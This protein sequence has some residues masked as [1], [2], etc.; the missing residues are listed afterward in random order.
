MKKWLLILVLC[1]GLTACNEQDL[2]LEETV[3]F[4]IGRA[5]V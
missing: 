3:E 5:H 4:K 1:L 2:P